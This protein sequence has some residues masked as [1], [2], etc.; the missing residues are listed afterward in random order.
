MKGVIAVLTILALSGCQTHLSLRDNTLQAS[1]TLTDLTYQQVLNNLA[2][3]VDNPS[4]LPAISLVNAG[5]VTVAD[6]K[7][8][9]AS[10][11][12]SPTVT[13]PQQ[14]GG[15][16]PILT[17]LFNPSGSRTV[18][19]NWSLVPVTNVDHLRR[20]RCAYQLLVQGG[21]A[22]PG[23]DDCRRTI[24]DFYP[25]KADPWECLIPQGWYASGCR[26][27]VPEDACHVGH[28]RD[29][30]VW[31]L[32]EG[33][34]GLTRFT[35]TVLDLATG[36]PH[37]PTRSVVKTLRPDGT[38]SQTQVTTTEIDEEALEKMKKERKHRDRPRPLDHGGPFNPGL[39]FIPAK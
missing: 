36:R 16:L 30:Y 2:L 24:E 11:T 35:L 21:N 7:S 33:V 19:E 4:S 32:P 26:T 13:F 8:I 10:T 18:T 6:G 15:T 12:Y 31:V 1:A 25:G 28:Y 22:P 20:V 29:T 5:T 38:L 39:F 23:C 9:N 27:D 17:L 14:A 37:T 34:D 3:F